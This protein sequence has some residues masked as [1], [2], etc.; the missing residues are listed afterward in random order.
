MDMDPQAAVT[1]GQDTSH[2][3]L[4]PPL[5]NTSTNPICDQV[6]TNGPDHDLAEDG[7]AVNRLVDVHIPAA[8]TRS[9]NTSHTLPKSPPLII[10]N[11]FEIQIHAGPDSVTDDPLLLLTPYVVNTKY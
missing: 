4:I 7:T 1:S 3:P 10:P 9:R 6:A 2:T 8:T 11:K 5:P